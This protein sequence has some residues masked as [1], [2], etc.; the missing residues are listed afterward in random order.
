MQGSEFWAAEGLAV[1]L[2]LGLWW[3]LGISFRVQEPGSLQ[4]FRVSGFGLEAP[5]LY[6]AL[7]RSLRV[8][9]I[10]P[11]LK[12]TRGFRAKEPSSWV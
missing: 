3:W 9:L 10:D 2:G 5:T 7:C 11:F 1:I 12:E 4:R 6:S 8:A